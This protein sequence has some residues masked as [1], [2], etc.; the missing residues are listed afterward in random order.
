VG[1]A[2]LALS[3]ALLVLGVSAASPLFTSF[4]LAALVFTGLYNRR[5]PR[6]LGRGWWKSFKDGRFYG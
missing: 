2:L 3:L 4:G 5:K 1:A 6:P